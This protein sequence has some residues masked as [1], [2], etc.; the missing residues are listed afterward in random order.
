[1]SRDAW[2][3]DKG[4]SACA[5]Y[6]AALRRRHFR[7]AIATSGMRVTRAACAILRHACCAHAS[8]EHQTLGLW[9]RWFQRTSGHPPCLVHSL[10]SHRAR[11][12]GDWA[13]STAGIATCYSP[14][15]STAPLGT[16]P[17]R[18]TRHIKSELSADEHEM[19][20]LFWHSLQIPTSDSCSE[21]A[22]LVMKK[23][24]KIISYRWNII[25]ILEGT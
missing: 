20:Y 18:I 4:D 17:I 23:L 5:R 16:P 10:H 6:L 13:R 2:M 7:P 8:Y 19:K 25:C 22:R 3:L 24:R 12:L 9:W 14:A 21:K 1:M 11:R 15:S